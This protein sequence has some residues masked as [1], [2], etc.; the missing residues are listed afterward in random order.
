[1]DSSQSESR[2]PRTNGIE[3]GLDNED[4]RSKLRPADIDA[5]VREMER[6]K[7]VEM[8]MSSKLFRE[9]LERII[10]LQ[11][12]DGNGPAG[13]LQQISDMMGIQSGKLHTTHMFRGN[14]L[15]CI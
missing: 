10:E 1:M 13:L 15:S 9:E 7:R 6:R 4:E 5:D 2:E 8:I 3:N 12:K 11:M 14:L